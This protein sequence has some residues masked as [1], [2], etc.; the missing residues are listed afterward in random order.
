MMCKLVMRSR[1]GCSAPEPFIHFLVGAG[2]S[3]VA[4]TDETAER[5]ERTNLAEQWD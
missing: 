1:A 2:C 3:S 4:S 5:F